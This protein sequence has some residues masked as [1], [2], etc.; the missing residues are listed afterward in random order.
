M[1]LTSIQLLQVV[2]DHASVDVCVCVFFEGA[3]RGRLLASSRTNVLPPSFES[4]DL[5]P[6]GHWGK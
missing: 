5:K 4:F 3:V 2:K 1:D 6:R